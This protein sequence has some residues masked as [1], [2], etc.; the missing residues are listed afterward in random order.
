MTE[1]SGRRPNDDV[2]V[3]ESEQESFPASDPPANTPETGIRV[4]ATTP[5]VVDNRAAH[6]FEVELD[7]QKAV[8]LYKRSAT[9]IELL[10]TEV[11]PAFR[12]RHY[13]DALAKAA[14]TTAR[15]EGLRTIV[16]CPFVKAYLKRHPEQAA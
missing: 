5:L 13:G 10:H 9:S 16:T 14:L 7:G 4:D 15:A 8:L 11:P 2:E 6:R 1:Q 3:D 12:G